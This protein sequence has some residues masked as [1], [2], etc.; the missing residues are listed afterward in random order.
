MRQLDRLRA[1]RWTKTVV[2]I[3]DF[4]GMA[5]VVDEEIKRARAKAAPMMLF[6]FGPKSLVFVAAFELIARYG[7]ASWFVYPIPSA[8]DAAYTQG[9]RD[10]IWIGRGKYDLA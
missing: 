6:P 7:R 9:T 3:T 2:A 8:Y 4:D 1:S 10:T 5:R